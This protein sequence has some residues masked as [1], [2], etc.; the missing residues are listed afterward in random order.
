V[1]TVRAARMNGL[2]MEPSDGK[3]GARMWKM[4][5]ADESRGEAEARYGRTCA[6]W[7]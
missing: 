1:V 6:R 7:E 5:F 3:A 4:R 2:A